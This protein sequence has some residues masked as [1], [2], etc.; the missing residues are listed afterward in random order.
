[1]Q[2]I[3]NTKIKSHTIHKNNKNI[4]F[5]K[6]LQQKTQ[7]EGKVALLSFLWYGNNASTKEKEHSMELPE[8]FLLLGCYRTLTPSFMLSNFPLP[9]FFSFLWNKIQYHRMETP[10]PP[11]NLVFNIAR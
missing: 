7:L 8:I 6:P 11:S 3:E 9:F 4:C 2:K 10:S 5:G 1:M